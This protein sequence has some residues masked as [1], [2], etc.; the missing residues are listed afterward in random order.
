VKRKFRA[1]RP[2]KMGTARSPWR[3]DN[4]TEE[5]IRTTALRVHL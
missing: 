3:D 2:V 4:H 1:P 5:A